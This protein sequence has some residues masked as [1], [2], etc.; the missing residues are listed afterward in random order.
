MET[1]EE[2]ARSI[3]QIGIYLDLYK[4]AHYLCT[5]SAVRS[6]IYSCLHLLPLQRLIP[7]NKCNEGGQEK[8]SPISFHTPHAIFPMHYNKRGQ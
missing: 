3:T 4:R 2:R 8:R 5:F 6:N 1:E 7:Q